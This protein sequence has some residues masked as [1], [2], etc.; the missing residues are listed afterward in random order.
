MEFH[1][2]AFRHGYDEAS[3]RHA[4]DHPLVVVELDPHGDPPKM[5]A[6]GADPAANLVEVIWLELAHD[7]ELVI[8]AMALRPMF[9]DL[10][11]T[12]EDPKP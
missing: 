5:L 4:L 7:V 11:P 9:Y 6:I 2:S 1:R 10:L 8:H 12:E 3:I